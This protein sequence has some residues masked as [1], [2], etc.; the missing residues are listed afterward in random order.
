EKSKNTKRY[1]QYTERLETDK[2]KLAE[3]TKGGTDNGTLQTETE[4]ENVAPAT[5]EIVETGA[6]AE[7]IIPK[8]GWRTP[9]DTGGEQ[10]AELQ[11]QGLPRGQFYSLDKPFESTVHTASNAKQETIPPLSKIYDPDGVMGKPT[12]SIQDEML[13]NIN[14]EKPQDYRQA[15]TDFL[16]SKGYDGYVRGIDGDSKNRELIVFNK[17]QEKTDTA[18][19][20]PLSQTDAATV[21]NTI[22]EAKSGE[23][24]KEPWEMTLEEY[25]ATAERKKGASSD[26]YLS[27][28]HSSQVR[29][30]VKQGE[31]VP[32]EVLKDY[33]ELQKLAKKT[34]ATLLEKTHPDGRE[35]T[36]K[37]KE[38]LYDKI[39]PWKINNAAF[40]Q[41]TKFPTGNRFNIA[42]MAQHQRIQEN[43]RSDYF[44]SEKAAQNWI[45]NRHKTLV[46]Q[47][48]KEGKDVPREVVEHYVGEK[49]ADDYLK[50]KEETKVIEPTK[51][52]E[53]NVTTPKE[54]K[55]YVVDKAESLLTDA[56]KRFQKENKVAAEK[57]DKEIEEY[58]LKTGYSYPVIDDESEAII[59]DVPN[60]GKY[61]IPNKYGKF[62]EFYKNIKRLSTSSGTEKTVKRALPKPT[63]K[64]IEQI[65]KEAFDEYMQAYYRYREDGNLKMANEL[66]ESVK[67][68]YPDE[69]EKIV[70]EEE[71]QRENL[72]GQYNNLLTTI[73]EAGGEI[74][75]WQNILSDI[76]DGEITLKSLSDEFRG[77]A[78][79]HKD[80]EEKLGNAKERYTQVNEWSDNIK[81]KIRALYPDTYQEMFAAVKVTDEITALEKE[82][83]EKEATAN[84]LR[85]KKK[86][87]WGIKTEADHKRSEELDRLRSKLKNM[88]ANEESTTADSGA[89]LTYNKRNRIKTGIK[90]EDIADK[91]TALK[92]KETNKQNVY[93]KPDYQQMIDDGGEPLIIHILKQVYDS[94]PIKPSVRNVV[95]DEDLKLYIT[96]VNRVM[97]GATAWTQDKGAIAAWAGKQ[98]KFAGAALGKPT[99]ITDLSESSKSLLDIIYPDG[100]KNYRAEVMVLGGNKLLKALQPGFEQGKK[101][102]KEIKEGWPVKQESWQKQGLKIISGDSL[103]S[104]T[105]SGKDS[106]DNPYTYVFIKTKIDGRT[107]DVE[108]KLFEGVISKDMPAVQDYINNRIESLKEKQILLDKRNRLIGEYKNS[109]EAQEA[110][111]EKVKR[112]N[113][114]TINEKGISVEAAE[115]IG[116]ERRLEGENVSS[117]KLRETFGFKGVN[118]GNWMKGDTNEAERQLH[119]NHAYDSF[120]DLAEILNVPPQ[121]MSLNGMLGV[122]IGAQGT[123]KH[124]AHFVPGV[125]E[126]NLTRTSGAG[127]LAHEFGHAIDHYFAR[128]A[129]L[130]AQAEPFL[131][132]HADFGIDAEGYTKRAGKKVKAFGE[133]IRPEITALFKSIVQ[134]MNK[135]TVEVTPEEQVAAM[136]ERKQHSVKNIEGWLRQIREDFVRSKVDVEQ[137]DKLVERIKNLDLGDGKIS[138]GSMYAISPVVAEMRDLY[139]K[140]T[141]HIYSI[142]QIKGLQANIDHLSYII[143]KEKEEHIPQSREVETDYSK[144]AGKL[145]RGKSGKKYW[146]TNLEKFAR[147]FD[148]YVSDTLEEKTAKNTYL[149]HAERNDETVPHGTERETINKAFDKLIEEIKTRETDKGVEMYSVRDSVRAGASFSEQLDDIASG[150]ITNRRQSI[151]ISDTPF[152]LEKLGAEQLPIV[153]THGTIEKATAGKHG[154]SFET[155]KQLPEQLADPVMVFDSATEADSLVVMTELKQDGKTIVA[156]VQL[157]KGMGNNI[158]NDIVSVHPRSNEYHFINWINQG[159]LRYMNKNKSR[160]WSLASGLQLPRV[161]G[162]K[163]GFKNKILFDYDIVKGKYATT[164]T[165]T[166]Q[167]PTLSEVQD[168]F[169]GQDVRQTKDGFIVNLPTGKGVLIQSVDQIT[170]DKMALSIGY[171]KTSLSENEVIAG[172]YKNGKI[173]L[174]KGAADKWTLAHEQTHWLEDLNIL[175]PLDVAALRGHIKRLVREGKFQTQNKEDIGGSEDRANFIADALTAPQKGSIKRIIDRIQDF[176][177]KL[178]NLVHRTT[179]GVVRDIR[180]GKIYNEKPTIGGALRDIHDEEGVETGRYALQNDSGFDNENSVTKD[181]GTGN[182]PAKENPTPE[183][184]IKLYRGITKN[185]QGVGTYSLGKGIYSSPDKKWLTKEFNFDKI[186][187]LSTEEAYPKNPLIIDAKKE[188]FTD[189][190]LR[191]SGE[192]N[193]RSFNKKYNVNEFVMSKGYDG[194]VN[195]NEIVKYANPNPSRSP[196]GGEQSVKQTKDQYSIRQQ[197]DPPVSS[198][199]KVLNFYL[200]DETDAIVQTIM[201]KLRPKN[202]TW[203]ET[204][205]KSPEWFDDSRIGNI[206]KLFMRDRNEIYHE[207]FN[208]LNMT[209]DAESPESTVTEAAKALKNKGL[210]LTE[211][212]A[213]KVSPE[214]KHLQEIIDEG[215]TSW[216]RNLKDPLDKQIKDFEN[217]IK[218]QGATEDTIR[219]W[220]LYRESYDKALELQTRQIRNMIADLIEE[221]H[222]KGETPDLRELKQTLKG[223]LAQMEEWKGFYAPRLREQGN[224]KV[225]AYKEHGPMKENREWYREHRGSELAAQRL[226]NNLKRE[227]WKIWDVGEVERIPEGI[228]QDV[229]AVATA[230]L[231]DSALEKLSKKSELRNNLTTEFNEEILRE[232][233]N[234][235]KARG[236]R[237]SM[238]HRG[239][240]AVVRGFIEDPIQRHLQYINNLSGGIA[241]ARVA[242]MAYQE[243]LGEKIMGKQVGGIDPVK[244]PKAY[245]VAQNYIEEQL[246]N[247]DSSDRII[248]LA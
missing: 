203:L 192:N 65:E 122:A 110:A 236:F 77:K 228:Y 103:F 231:I 52:E 174:V 223:A 135:K 109:E 16:M 140:T 132:E 102:L 131:T 98:A 11:S 127:S 133:G 6:K 214:Y 34:K 227:G 182:I 33:P 225:Q 61:K 4:I 123:G 3:L 49:W 89:E 95:T 128:Q 72:I 60:D 7:G 83:S 66:K 167:L 191:E 234:A 248:G 188:S 43:G 96:A 159:L 9:V 158:V 145:D 160:A 8:T 208:D 150:K 31:N 207:T 235:I 233:S 164:Q 55:A 168:V 106:H 17:E 139:K 58:L 238:I 195:G 10:I 46:A 173:E 45:D 36:V 156:A 107:V 85:G 117:D 166:F 29:M 244:E 64:P 35:E 82:I 57:S 25:L 62:S 48:I 19:P 163:L 190:L 243:L 206:V 185:G 56:R 54:Q 130:E 81:S 202:M 232:V 30:A 134:S 151:E 86:G 28:Y 157:S 247:A 24:L 129:G 224:W 20:A 137:Y 153:V 210:S 67:E 171:S 104:D 118:F 200:K 204:M 183:A 84:Y 74:D 211:R 53:K 197:T 78:P 116:E 147:A 246:R 113:K 76:D 39:E 37:T 15:M 148:A 172:K 32:P 13:K 63:G 71:Q 222:F 87:A 170:P 75:K 149:S 218:E 142:D 91:N 88:K 186:I 229:N 44:T 115:R 111:R 221:A 38:N 230:K 50:S 121:A 100:W 47:A 180:T 162:S 51:A 199:P 239:R 12:P 119:L 154:I 144:E 138:I 241:K 245:T 22:D 155:L 80:I 184:G 5:P 146:S 213:G 209:D 68:D 101:A 23:S 92:V 108:T 141:G 181:N 194:V 42:G 27:G 198:D 143:S 177:D 41:V 161:S 69:Y 237:S 216:K 125:N 93:P 136:G 99:S 196:M 97:E 189:W 40:G 242:R 124:A 201:N 105:Y 70:K 178:I 175:R 73:K 18:L 187:E 212:I 14:K 219:V 21:G 176:I 79:S 217:H 220:K 59:I 193:I 205:L 226:A 94:I 169:K 165:G 240:G 90:W 179:R 1:K 126:I 114:P 26:A 215:D 2:A 112:E 152:V 120:M